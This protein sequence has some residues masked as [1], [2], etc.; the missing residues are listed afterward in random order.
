M[1]PIPY[2]LS[3]IPLT[4]TGVVPLAR[5]NL[6]RFWPSNP[7]KPSSNIPSAVAPV[8]PFLVEK[9]KALHEISV[10]VGA[11]KVYCIIT[12]T[13]SNLPLAGI[14]LGPSGPLGKR[15][16]KS[17]SLLSPSDSKLF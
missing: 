7:S 14:S 13:S 4:S 8:A 10:P 11:I 2:G 12:C 9:V 16:S 3:V 17:E 6:S 15:K 1:G 5:A